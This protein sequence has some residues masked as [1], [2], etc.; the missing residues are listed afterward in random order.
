M[1]SSRDVDAAKRL[2]PSDGISLPAGPHGKG[3]GRI[4]ASA[5]D[6]INVLFQV[7]QRLLRHV[8]KLI[9]IDGLLQTQTSTAGPVSQGQ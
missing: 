6:L 5:D 1:N 3:V 7:N 8:A 9:R 2:A 4:E